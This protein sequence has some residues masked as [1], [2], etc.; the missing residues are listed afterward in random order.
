MS[1]V[2]KSFT[3][4][5]AR[6]L[7]AR[8]HDG[9]TDKNGKPYIG[10]LHRVASYVTGEDARIA[11]YLHDSIEDT[12]VTAELLV[13]YGVPAHVVEAVVVLTRSDRVA[14]EAYYAEIRA[15]ALAL[16]VKLGDLADNTDPRRR[17]GLDIKTRER[18]ERKYAKAYAHLGVGVSDGSLRRGDES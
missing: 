13:E 4:D 15:H 8:L 16:E 3:A 7:A 10:H 17:E 2:T 6:S 12:G 5:D 9:Q 1:A 18:L 14:P 11:A